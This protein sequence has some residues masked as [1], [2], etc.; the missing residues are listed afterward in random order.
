MVG[1]L[2]GIPTEL[3]INPDEIVAMGAAIVAAQSVGQQIVDKNLDPLGDI[4]I[5]DVTAHSLGVLTTDS[6]TDEQYNTIVVPKNTAL[7]FKISEMFTTLR[8]NQTKMSCVILQGED[9]D[10]KHCTEVG[11]CL[12]EGIPPM[13]K[14]EPEVEDT[15]SYDEEGVI[16]FSAKELSTGATVQT[17]IECPWLLSGEERQAV[18]RKIDGSTVK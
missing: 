2:T 15:F 4:S 10:P 8:D 3:G 14:G 13:P 6:E 5:T 16:Q 18:A 1:D 11:K 12:L 9:R 17:E 7:P